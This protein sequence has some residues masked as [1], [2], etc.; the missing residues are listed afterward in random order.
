MRTP[1]SKD[2]TRP[3]AEPNILAP[4]LD[5]G[6]AAMRRTRRPFWQRFTAPQ[7]FVGSFL[8]LIALGTIG[9]EVLPGLYKA[10]GLGWKDALFTATSAVCVTGL[11]VVDTATFFTGWGQAYVLLLIQAGGLGI[12]TF[13]TLIINALGLRLSLRQESIVSSASTFAPHIDPKRLTRDVVLFTF[14]VEGAGAL[15]LWV[16]WTPKYGALHALWPAVFHS[17]SAFCN[18]GFSTFSTSLMGDA[19]N[20]AVLLVVMVLIVVGGIGFLVLEELYLLARAR[21]R[22]Q[23]FRLS[24]HSRLVLA[25]TAVLIVG[26]WMLFTLFEWH[27]TLGEMPVGLKLVNGLFL[28]VTARTAGFNSVDYAAA[29][30]NSNFLTILLMSIGGSPGS[31][32]GGLKTTTIALIG[33]VAWARMR[34][35]EHVSIWHRSVPAETQQR[36]ISLFVVAFGVVTAAIFALTTS[37]TAWVNGVGTTGGTAAFLPLMFEAASAFNTVGLSMG[38]TGGLSTTGRDV[39]ILLMFMGRVGPLTFAAALSRR[40]RLSLFHYANE[41][42]GV[43]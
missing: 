37:D 41:D 30:S 29:A 8:A 19:G 31:T 27:V 17:I 38:V 16:L 7:L 15:L 1:F 4:P 9:F 24:L 20:P 10:E 11:I 22:R 6:L 26:G 43:G 18:A 32:A 42:V 12:I 2:A 33:L 35:H 14:A 21:R 39:L 23:V 28:S 34:G 36:A 5:P 3:A 40:K 25:T 13:T